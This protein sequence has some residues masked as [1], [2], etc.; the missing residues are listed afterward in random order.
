MNLH[1][2]HFNK[3]IVREGDHRPLLDDRFAL[4]PQ[5]ARRG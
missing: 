1:F 3:Q 4:K 2:V 5:D